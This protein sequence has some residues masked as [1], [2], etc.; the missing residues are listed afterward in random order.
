MSKKRMENAFLSVTQLQQLYDADVRYEVISTLAVACKQLLNLNFYSSPLSR[1]H[2]NAPSSACSKD[3][4]KSAQIKIRSI[5]N[6]KLFEII[7]DEVL[8]L[9]RKECDGV[10]SWNRIFTA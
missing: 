10:S 4:Q 7:C 1:S 8:F 3:R 9:K 5:S 2:Y 6:E